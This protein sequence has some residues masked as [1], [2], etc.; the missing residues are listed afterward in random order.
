MSSDIAIVE[1]KVYLLKREDQTYNRVSS[2]DMHEWRE[3]WTKS[4]VYT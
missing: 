3:G 2:H 1:E 4:F